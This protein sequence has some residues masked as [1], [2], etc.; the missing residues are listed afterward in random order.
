MYLLDTDVLSLLRRPDRN[1][2]VARWLDGVADR[3]LWL[4]AVTIGEIARG[5]ALQRP[6]D[7]DFAA[8]LEAWFAVLR[9]DYASRVLPFGPAEAALWGEL[10]ARLGHASA[11]L[12]IAATAM[13]RG[14]TVVTRNLRHYEPTGAAVLDPGA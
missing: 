14:L 6:R 11:D 9:R 8:E 13:A 3:D 2:A 12:M 10:S 5:I 4:S 1:P 7:A